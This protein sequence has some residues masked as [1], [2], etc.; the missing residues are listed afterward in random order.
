LTLVFN[1]AL[2]SVKKTACILQNLLAQAQLCMGMT[3]Q[4]LESGRILKQMTAFMQWKI[5][6]KNS[7]DL[8]SWL[9][10]NSFMYTYVFIPDRKRY[11]QCVYQVPPQGVSSC[12]EGIT[13]FV[14]VG[15]LQN[16]DWLQKRAWV[17]LPSCMILC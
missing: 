5:L 8:M 6:F 11:G 10:N 14:S 17:S 16:L 13:I 12:S 1:L 3:V 4:L 2:V 15:S 7:S 9:M